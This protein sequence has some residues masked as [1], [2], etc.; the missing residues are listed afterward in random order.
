MKIAF[1]DN[2]NN[3][4]YGFC[5]YLRD[6]KLEVDLFEI[7]AIST[8]KPEDDTFDDVTSEYWIKKFP[9]P[10]LPQFW[11][12]DT[13]H[14]LEPFREYDL[15]VTCGYCPAFFHRAGIRT[16]IF[17]PYGGDLDDY[18]INPFHYQGLISQS[19]LIEFFTAHYN[20]ILCSLLFAIPP[21]V[22]LDSLKRLNKPYF[23]EQIP[24]FYPPPVKEGEGHRMGKWTII[25]PCRHLWLSPF[26]APEDYHLYGGIKRNDKIILAL[27]KIKDTNRDSALMPTLKIYNYGP[28]FEHSVNLAR[29]LG[30]SDMISVS[31][32]SPRREIF[33]DMS[34]A[35]AVVGAVRENYIGIGGVGVEAMAAGTPYIGY[36]PRNEAP[37]FMNPP[38]IHVETS[39]DIASAILMLMG[40]PNV[41]NAIG[42]Q[43]KKWFD[44]NC[45]HGKAQKF[46]NFFDELKE[47]GESKS[48]NKDLQEIARRHFQYVSH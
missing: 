4:F 12:Q 34:E 44:L 26:N 17:I 14:L 47:R 36:M 33:Q 38:V 7:P 19:A 46:I 39:D 22:M 13:N 41:S 42:V 16:H 25:N 20:Q 31:K 27:K 6:A 32:R 11:T 43:Q 15:I 21:T 45:G 1:V 18:F 9:F 10:T 2:M 35:S 28:D 30:L 8:F 40:S 24:I 48:S 37:Q 23:H 5:R 29:Y 3:N